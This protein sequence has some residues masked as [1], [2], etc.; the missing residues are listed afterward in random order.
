M[1]RSAEVYPRA[2]FTLLEITVAL[3]LGG[4]TVL[5][6][7]SLFLGM[8]GKDAAIRALAERADHDANGEGLL[9]ALFANLE[10]TRDTTPALTGDSLGVSFLAWCPTGA[11]RLGH[12]GV[13]LY[14]E[15][16]GPNTLLQVQLRAVGRDSAD[17]DRPIELR[18]GAIGGL[19]YLIDPGGGGRWARTWTGRVPPVAVAVIIDRDTLL[20]PV[21]GN[22]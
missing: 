16:H 19:R 2:G 3:I 22:D 12:C 14:L 6:A 10:I 7:A 17:G 15:S 11:E 9:R 13:R 18:R 20:L 21:W 8:V 4:M 5:G 1:T